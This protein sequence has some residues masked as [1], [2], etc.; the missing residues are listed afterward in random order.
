MSFIPR[1]IIEREDRKILDLLR[2]ALA[3]SG[4]EACWSSPRSLSLTDGF[5]EGYL[6]YEEDH[7]W[8]VRYKERGIERDEGTFPNSF[9]AVEFLYSKLIPSPSPFEFREEWKAATGQSFSLVD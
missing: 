8:Q 3:K 4:I 2:F 7:K 6:I 9:N 5:D 1:H